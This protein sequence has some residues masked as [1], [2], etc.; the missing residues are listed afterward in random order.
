MDGE[1]LLRQG[2]S[3]GQEGSGLSKLRPSDYVQ[4]S[5][6]LTKAGESRVSGPHSGTL[7]RT[8]ESDPAHLGDLREHQLQLED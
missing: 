2:S 3:D 8:P 1:E 7:P 4:F 6:E 5:K